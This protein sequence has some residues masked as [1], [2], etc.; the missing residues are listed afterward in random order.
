MLLTTITVLFCYFLY[1]NIVEELTFTQIFELKIKNK[2]P[3]LMS[4]KDKILLNAISI[5]NTLRV[6]FKNELTY[7][8]NKNV[9]DILSFYESNKYDISDINFF[10]QSKVLPIEQI[11]H[12]TN[13][14]ENTNELEVILSHVNNNLIQYKDNL[15]T[16][17]KKINEIEL[18][19]LKSFYR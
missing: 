16:K 17:D 14:L 11:I 4:K 5:T 13:R 10:I 6:V 1:F 3:Y 18:K 8:I 19:V 12:H 7:N 9:I 2:I 15:I